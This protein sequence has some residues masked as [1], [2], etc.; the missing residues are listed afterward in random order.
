[1]SSLHLISPD[2]PS[3]STHKQRN[4]SPKQ[5]IS[6][7]IAGTMKGQPKR[8]VAAASSLTAIGFIIISA[9]MARRLY[10]S[11]CCWFVEMMQFG[12]VG[13]Y[14]SLSICF[15]LEPYNI[16]TFVCSFVFLSELP[17][18]WK[19]KISLPDVGQ[20]TT[21][22]CA[23]QCHFASKLFASCVRH[24]FVSVCV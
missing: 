9:L 23:S 22:V 13:A 21:V 5:T 19:A 17:K 20:Q 16:R 15:A 4:K 10:L 14:L 6:L 1:M 24:L 3:K 11:S 7:W 2:E 18:Y 12:L 8:T